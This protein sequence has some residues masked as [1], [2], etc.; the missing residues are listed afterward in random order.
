ML[1]IICFL[2]FCVSPNKDVYTGGRTFVNNS[3][4]GYR[5]KVT[6]GGWERAGKIKD[7]EQENNQRFEK[8]ALQGM[9]SLPPEILQRMGDELRG[10]GELI[11]NT[12]KDAVVGTVRL[13]IPEYAKCQLQTP[14]FSAGFTGTTS[15]NVYFGTTMGMD[16]G[17]KDLTTPSEKLRLPTLKGMVGCSVGYLLARPSALDESTVDKS[18]AGPDWEVSFPNPLLPETGVTFAGPLDNNEDPFAV[19]FGFP[20]GFGAGVSYTSEKIYD[21]DEGC[22]FLKPQ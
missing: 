6:S 10:G 20:P 3:A 21:W 12:A 7:F 17:L 18:V 13:A 11:A 15:G 4:D 16:S 1:F 8:A 19:E 5:Y 9:E 22:L 2:H 14:L